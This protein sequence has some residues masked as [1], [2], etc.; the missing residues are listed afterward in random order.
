MDKF[1]VPLLKRGIIGFIGK[2]RRSPQIVKAIK[3]YSAVYFLAPAGLGALLSERVVGKKCIAFK[4]LGP[5]AIY[6]LRVKNF[7][8]IV[9]I[10]TRGRD[11]YKESK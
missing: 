7:P 5:E 3:K 11:I 6:E 9:G 8:L 2:G 1:T 10:D 4:D